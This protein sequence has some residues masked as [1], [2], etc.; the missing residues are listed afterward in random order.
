MKTKPSTLSITVVIP[1]L[2]QRSGL[3]R[4]LTALDAGTR[5]ANQI[6]VVDN[7][8][9][10]PPDDICAE[11]EGVSL[12]HQP[13]A[14]PGLARNMGVAR[15]TGDILAFI[16]ADCIPA[17]DWIATAEQA[18]GDPKVDILG[19]DVRIEYEDPAKLTVLEAYE[20]IFA[21]RMDRYIRWQGFTG[22]GNLVVRRSVFDQVGPFAGMAIAEDR[23]WG[24]RATGLGF[25]IRYLPA[26]R[27]F[28]PAR[29]SFYDLYSKW[30][31]QLAHDRQGCV[32]WRDRLR[33]L[34]KAMAL[35]VSPLAEIPRIATCT[36]VSGLA[37]RIRAFAG[38]TRIRLYRAGRMIQLAAGMDADHLV[39]RWNRSDAS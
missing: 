22:T 26:I 1:H 12:M 18:M 6:I 23:D 7:G 28:H 13:L 19:G 8:S 3:L 33:W 4:C 27:V 31:R 25:K 5:A 9:N 15:S 11:F 24:Q 38:L 10:Q 39:Q 20:S 2:N 37:N 34:G 21:Y 30:D 32:T 17:D 35:S 29:L 36:R 14:G 16:D